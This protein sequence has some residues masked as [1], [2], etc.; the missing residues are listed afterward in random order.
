M[1]EQEKWDVGVIGAGPGG[2]SAAHELRKT[3]KFN[4]V[5]FE[6]GAQVGGRAS[7][8][9]K[10]GLAFDRGANFYVLKYNNTAEI[11]KE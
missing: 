9:V 1:N 10:D 3:G 5:V 11:A 4:V 7:T 2:L 8:R 6:A